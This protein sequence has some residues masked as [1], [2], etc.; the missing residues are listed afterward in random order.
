LGNW[1]K[2]EEKS[3]KEKKAFHDGKFVVWVERA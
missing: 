1:S 3:G 2:T